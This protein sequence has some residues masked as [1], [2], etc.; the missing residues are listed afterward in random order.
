MKKETVVGQP[1]QKTFDLIVNGLVVHL[2]YQENGD[3]LE[4]L[5][6]QHLSTAKLT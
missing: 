6:Y 2:V 1:L 5:L 4:K 3:S